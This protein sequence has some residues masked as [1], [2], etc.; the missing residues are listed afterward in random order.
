[1]IAV[2]VL[3]VGVVVGVAGEHARV[4]APQKLRRVESA[5]LMPFEAIWV[6]IPFRFRRLY[7]TSIL[8]SQ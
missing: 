7:V 4:P 3:V 5:E 8:C 6:Q 2:L 1:V